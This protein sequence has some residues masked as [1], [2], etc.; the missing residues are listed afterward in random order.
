MRLIYPLSGNYLVNNIYDQWHRQRGK[1]QV[2]LLQVYHPGYEKFNLGYY[3]GGQRICP[4]GTDPDW[5]RVQ[6]GGLLDFGD[7]HVHITGIGNHLG[8]P[9]FGTGIHTLPGGYNYPGV[10][11]H[12]LLEPPQNNKESS[13]DIYVC[14]FHSIIF[15]HQL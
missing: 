7:V 13:D 12:L 6:G 11:D 4:P 10:T 14:N 3:G 9:G 2:H 5:H 15:Y 1:T 8:H